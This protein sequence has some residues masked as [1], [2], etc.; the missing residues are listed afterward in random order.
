MI[1]NTYSQIQDKNRNALTNQVSELLY[2]NNTQTQ[3]PIDANALE[4][5]LN[6]LE[7]DYPHIHKLIMKEVFKKQV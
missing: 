2:K 7:E 4:Q 6:I 5:F 3:K 1:L